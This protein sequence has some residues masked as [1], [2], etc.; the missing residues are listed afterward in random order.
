M[1]NSFIN[2]AGGS[3]QLIFQMCQFLTYG[4][5]FFSQ[6][7]RKYEE[8]LQEVEKGK[9]ACLLLTALFYIKFASN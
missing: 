6:L 7:C 1:N 2:S 5:A 9:K 8:L 4:F 3:L